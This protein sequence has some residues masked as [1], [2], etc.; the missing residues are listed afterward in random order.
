MGR[1]GAVSPPKLKLGL[2]N[3]FPDA[4]AADLH[5]TYNSNTVI[6]YTL[7]LP[8]NNCGLVSLLNYSSCHTISG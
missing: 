4:S 5:E 6:A 7:K 2:Q 8:A 1:E 3:Y